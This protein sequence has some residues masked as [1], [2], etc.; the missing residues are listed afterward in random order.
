[1]RVLL[2]DDHPLIRAAIQT[3]IASLSEQVEVV[4][5]GTAAE[6]RRVLASDADFDLA[7]IDL[8]L[9]DA[10]GFELLQ[11]VRQNHPSIP[12]VVISGSDRTADVIRAIDE[13]AMGFIPKRTS[14]EVLVHALRMVMSGGIYV[15]PMALRSDL[16][17]REEPELP[18]AAQRPPATVSGNEI[19]RVTTMLNLTPRQ[20]DVLSLL[21]KGQANKT[22]A[23]ELGLSVETVKDHVAS[24]LRSLG[25]N[26]RTQA[27]LAVG[28]LLQR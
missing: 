12:A 2:I 7:L 1:M 6:A 3:V 28:Q 5:V 15:P 23:R 14:N 20:G 24:L 4:G 11:E 22:I 18:V 27:V 19:D 16:P 17:P 13:G 25:V 8:Q 21:L 26:S 10:N 9:T